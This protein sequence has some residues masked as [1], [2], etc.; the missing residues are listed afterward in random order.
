MEE[1]TIKFK[2]VLP[3]VDILFGN[4][5]DFCNLLQLQNA[6]NFE[7]L[8]LKSYYEN[9]YSR[10][11]EIYDI[12]YFVTS[13]RDVASASHNIYQG[14]LYHQNKIYQSKKYSID[15]IDRV[16]TGDAFSAG[17]LYSYIVEMS[18][19]DKV[20]FATA[21]AAFKHT[22]PGDVTLAGVEEIRSLMDSNSFGVQR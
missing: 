17:F 19:Q 4:H 21:S 12:E 5:L 16:G 14:M 11:K 3:Y 1:A 15:I 7:G 22:I 2:E 10:M 13:I 6:K 9:L 20:D 8:D 18:M